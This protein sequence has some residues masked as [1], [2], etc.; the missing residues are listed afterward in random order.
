MSTPNK[1]Y[2]HISQQPTE[3]IINSRAYK[4]R[5]WR[6]SW[7]NYYAQEGLNFNREIRRKAWS[8]FRDLK[9]EE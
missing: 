6:N 4:R 9:V 5:K 2:Q 3:G 8:K 1:Y 7:Q